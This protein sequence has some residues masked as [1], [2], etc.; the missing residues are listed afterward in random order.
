MS[1]AK[2]YGADRIWI[3]NVGSFK[4]QEF[5]MEFF[6]NL[7][8]NT[9]RWTAANLGDYTRLWAEREFG[10]EHAAEIAAIVTKYTKFNG[11]R[12]PE[13]IDGTTFSQTSYEEADKVVADWAALSAQAEALSALLPA[14]TR[15]AF[16]QLVL[17]PTKAA[18]QY[19]ALYAAVGKNSLHAAQKR[20]TANDL[21]TQVQTLFTADAT[22]TTYYHTTL[23]AG[24]WNH[25]MDEP[26]IGYNTWS[27]PSANTKPTTT[28]LS[29]PTAAAMGVTV[30]GTTLSWPGGTG[31]PTLA[32]FDVFRQQQNYI[33]VFNKGK[34]SFNATA[35]ASAP[36]IIVQGG[37]S[38]T[39]AKEQRL[40]V[41][42]NWA[43]APTGTTSGTVT[44]SGASSTVSVSVTAFKPATPAR[45]TLQGFVEGEGYVAIEPEHHTKK[46]NAGNARWERLPDYGP[47]LSGMRAAAPVDTAGLAAGPNSPGLEYSMYLFTT[48]TVTASFTVGPALNFSPDRGVRLAAAFDNETPQVVTIVAQGYSTGNGVAT[49][50][51]AVRNNA[52]TVKTTHS[53]AAAGYHTLKVWMVD[54]AV[55]LQK[56]VVNL[57]GVKTSYLGP[58]E[59]YHRNTAAYTGTGAVLPNFT[60]FRSQYFT[61]DQLTDPAVSGAT[62]TPMR[63]GMGNLLKYGLGLDPTQA[64]AMTGLPVIGTSGGALTITFIRLRDVADIIYTVE[65]SDDLQTW[66]SGPDYTEQTTVTGLDEFYDQV[67]VRDLTASSGA[68]KRFIRLKITQQ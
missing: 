4:G 3:V 34:N 38:F 14:S 8:W 65:V 57:G 56:I 48:G 27:P 10:P 55:V 47:T 21:V 62:A 9:P 63:D 16:F 66:H 31:T 6:L 11:R 60:A 49:W 2:Q 68:T 19:N 37:P 46:T 12:K 26:H 58:P 36:W 17:F 28:T 52:W 29:L 43:L 18:Y 35:T 7:G 32:K 39:V 67:V 23:A 45:E 22:L 40:W 20:A 53:I 50:E 25:F 44:L 64:A 51:T 15:D 33:D 42:V 30:A 61:A 54:P 24:K 5:P 41:S 59:S 1:L 13:S